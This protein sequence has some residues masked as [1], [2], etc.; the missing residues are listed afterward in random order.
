MWIMGVSIDLSLTSLRK[1]GATRSELMKKVAIRSLKLFA[2]GL[3]VNNGANLPHWRITGVLQYF[4]F[5]YFVVCAV[6]IFCVPVTE[7]RAEE[8]VPKQTTGSRSD[9][10]IPLLLP[11]ADYSDASSCTVG[12]WT[13]TW[14]DIWPYRSELLGIAA[15]FFGYI[16]CTHIL[17]SDGCPAG[18]LGPGGLADHSEHR[19]CT[20]GFHR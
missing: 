5:S 19:D 12:R 7:A 9:V 15:W 16:L 14:Y 1:K 18:Y 11:E 3:F 17:A 2:L 4:A 8:E 6:I 10:D 13:V 20:G